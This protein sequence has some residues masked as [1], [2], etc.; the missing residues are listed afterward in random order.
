MK[1]LVLSALLCSSLVQADPLRIAVGGRYLPLHGTI[2]GAPGGLE[3]ELG[4]L[5]GAELGREVVFIAPGDLKMSS[6]DAVAQGKADITLNSVTPTPEREKL[7]SFTP[8]YVTLHYALAAKKGA[9]FTTFENVKG[10]VA[11]VT[12]PVR[13][14]AEKLLPNALFVEFKSTQTAIEKLAAG[15]VDY[16]VA[17]DVGVL[18]AIKGSGLVVV[19]PPFGSAPVALGAPLGQ[20][21]PYAAALEKLKPKLAELVQKWAPGTPYVS[22]DEK[23]QPGSTLAITS[24][25]PET[26]FHASPVDITGTTSDD[27]TE[28]TVRA[29]GGDRPETIKRKKG[30]TDFTYKLRLHRNLEVGQNSLTFEAKCAH[31]DPSAELTVYFADPATM[32]EMAKPVVY[33]YPTRP[34]AVTVR[35]RPEG[36]VTV[37]EPAL[38]DGA[39]RVRAEPDG[40][41]TELASRRQWRSL[42]WEGLSALKP[43]QDGFCVAQEALPAFFAEK[44]RTLGLRGQE[45]ADFTEYWLPRLRDAKAQRISFVSRAALDAHAPL[46]ISP[47]PDTLIR[48]YFFHQPAAACDGTETQAVEVAPA[49]R[50]FTA[51][52]WGGN[53]K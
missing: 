17:E 22:P 24:P 42:Y 8:P 33:L 23:N 15:Y 30:A 20:A 51:V 3:I 47:A 4:R 16:L 35:P 52:E 50:G 49:R 41:L 9:T 40:R 48:V 53:K 29:T 45:V 46:D 38:A 32:G 10:R 14:G 34:E 31:G 18:A 2:G 6:I 37:A 26:M 43:P 28:L 5:L 13:A 44:L 19:A 39:W 25:A 12:G 11:V 27:C 36:G 1:R 21:A 7:I